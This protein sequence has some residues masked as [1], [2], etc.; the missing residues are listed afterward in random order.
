MAILHRFSDQNLTLADTVGLHI[1][2]LRGVRE[3][4]STDC[5]LDLTGVPLVVHRH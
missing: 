3:C 2:S 1:I 5:H 4:W